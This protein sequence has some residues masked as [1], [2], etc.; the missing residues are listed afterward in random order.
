[1]SLLSLSIIAVSNLRRW[2]FCIGSSTHPRGISCRWCLRHRCSRG[3]MLGSNQYVRP[4]ISCLA[5]Q[6]WMLMFWTMDSVLESSSQLG[7]S[8]SRLIAVRWSYL[9]CQNASSSFNSAPHIR[10]HSNS[11]PVV[12]HETRKWALH[13]FALIYIGNIS[14]WDEIPSSLVALVLAGAMSRS[15]LKLAVDAYVR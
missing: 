2:K 14:I 5:T 12:S 8:F 15:N 10:A 7:Q 4:M 13:S 6:L 11:P 1:M 3:Y 9:R